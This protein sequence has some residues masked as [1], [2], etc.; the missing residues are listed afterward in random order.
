MQKV[1]QNLD[2]FLSRVVARGNKTESNMRVGSRNILLNWEPWLHIYISFNTQCSTLLPC[3]L[4]PSLLFYLARR[5]RKC[6]RGPQTSG[7][8]IHRPNAK[9]KKT[10]CLCASLCVLYTQT[11]SFRCWLFFF[12]LQT[13]CSLSFSPSRSI[14]CFIYSQAHTY[15]QSIINVGLH[16]HHRHHIKHLFSKCG[17]YVLLFSRFPNI[18]L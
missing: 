7:I 8:H 15:T 12:I 1:K 10:K 13:M 18:P 9:K 5:I 17:K 2:F 3:A 14:F 16:H 11:T 6:T 4:F